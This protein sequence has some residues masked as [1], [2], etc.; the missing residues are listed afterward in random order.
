MLNVVKFRVRWRSVADDSMDK[1]EAI[2]N[3]FVDSASRFLRRNINIKSNRNNDYDLK[4]E[5]VREKIDIR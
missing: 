1:Q 3:V 2:G 5:E 4:K